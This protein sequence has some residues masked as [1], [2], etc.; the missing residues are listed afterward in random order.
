MC[1]NIIVSLSSHPNRINT[2]YLA[3]N[4]ILEGSYI[5]FKIVL[6]LARDDFIGQDLN[7]IANGITEKLTNSASGGFTNSAS[8]EINFTDDYKAGTKL[9]PTL[10]KYPDHIIVTI[11]DDRLYNKDF[12]NI[13][14]NINKK[15]PDQII[16]PVARKYIFNH[17]QNLDNLSASYNVDNFD[18]LY[19]QR[20]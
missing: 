20:Y 16:C 17:Q 15:F 9:I 14:Y 18:F 1:N 8:V 2:T 12:L 3:I 10:L 19:Q 13:L 6:N 11:D 4:S 5:P 7:K